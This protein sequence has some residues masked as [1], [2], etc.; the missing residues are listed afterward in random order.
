MKTTIEELEALFDEQ[1][2][3]LPTG[4]FLNPT[5]E[6]ETDS[7]IIIRCYYNNFDN[8][9]DCWRYSYDKNTKEITA[10]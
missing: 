2:G 10:S 6:T 8:D 3:D 5:V 4:G 7:E 9:E 1:F